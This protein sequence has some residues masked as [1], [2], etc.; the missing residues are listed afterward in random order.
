MKKHNDIVTNQVDWDSAF[1][2]RVSN[3]WTELVESI[4]SCKDCAR[5]DELLPSVDGIIFPDPLHYAPKVI[6]LLVSW[7]PPGKPRAVR[8]KQ[9]FHNSSSSD[10]LRSRVFNILTKTK[11]ELQLDK[12]QPKQSLDRFYGQGFY[13]VPTIFRRIKNDV[14]PSDRLVEH[15]S[16]THLKEILIFLAQR[17][18]RLRVIL[19]G[20]TPTRAFAK[21]FQKHEAARKIAMALRGRS[22]VATARNLT[23]QRPLNFQIS[24]DSY[25]D[26]WISNW[27]RG[28]GYKTLSDDITRALVWPTEKV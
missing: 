9:F 22:P 19:L 8:E 17:Q 25:L 27:G 28:E 12:N 3:S 10:N 11:P 4:M 6:L 24:T 5:F 15:S 1:F 7:A 16:Q 18:G 26:V 23:M 13:L 21:L 2:L 20:E 14:E